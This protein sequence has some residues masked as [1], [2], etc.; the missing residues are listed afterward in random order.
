MVLCRYNVVLCVTFTSTT[1]T[2]VAVVVTVAVVAVVFF[3]V[4][5]VVVVVVVVGAVVI[6]AAIVVVTVVVVTFHTHCFN[7][8]EPSVNHV[9]VV[10][11]S[12]PASNY[13]ATDR[14]RET[15]RVPTS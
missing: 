6:F 14:V 5:V 4:V 1:Y 8:D 9:V 13:S 2:C 15:S 10:V 3:I 7:E 12:L 11:K